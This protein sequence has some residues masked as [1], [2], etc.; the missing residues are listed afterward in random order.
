[1][2]TAKFDRSHGAPRTPGHVTTIGGAA[3]TSGLQPAHKA[4]PEQTFPVNHRGG[5]GVVR[6]ET[7]GHATDGSHRWINRTH[8][9]SSRQLHT[10]SVQSAGTAPLGSLN[11]K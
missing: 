3:H 10:G 2:T 8:P 4:P 9:T 7:V 1:M 11:R 5:P 6:A